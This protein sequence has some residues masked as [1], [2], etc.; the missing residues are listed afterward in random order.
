[1]RFSL[2]RLYIF[3]FSI[4]NDPVFSIVS[5]NGYK[6]TAV[7]PK[8]YSSIPFFSFSL[9]LRSL[10]VSLL[11][12]HYCRFDRFIRGYRFTLTKYFYCVF[13]VMSSGLITARHNAHLFFTT[14]IIFISSSVAFF[15]CV[16]LLSVSVCVCKRSFVSA[17]SSPVLFFFF[18]PFSI[19]RH[20]VNSP[21]TCNDPSVLHRLGSFMW[22]SGCRWAP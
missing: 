16:T 4:G 18:L 17:T 22:C 7:A 13:W 5:S 10:G 21:A 14:F 2:A 19:R 20:R 12:L 8:G 1:M 15:F 9:I 6:G 11:L 3:L